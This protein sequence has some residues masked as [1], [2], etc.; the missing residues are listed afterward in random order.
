MKEMG[1]WERWKKVWGRSVELCWGGGGDVG[2]VYKGVE[3]CVGMWG[4]EER[5]GKVGDSVGRCGGR[6]RKVE[7]GLQRCVRRF[8]E[9]CK[10][11]CRGVGK[12]EG[13]SAEVS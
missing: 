13:R 12:C 8:A 7:E 11:V 9:V 6:C 5:W 2:E 3:K 4:G 1:C 10:E